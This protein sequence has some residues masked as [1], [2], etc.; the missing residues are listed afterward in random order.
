M[1]IFYNPRCQ[2]CRTALKEICET[3]LEPEIIDY[4]QHPPTAEELKN[5]IKMLGIIPLD[6]IRTK[7]NLFQEK[8]AGKQF[9]DDQWIYTMIEN[10]SLI[11]R[12]IIIKDNVE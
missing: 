9:S 11:E 2:K 3:G 7:E 4:M 8:F 1:K 10:P 12:P 5:I 6:L